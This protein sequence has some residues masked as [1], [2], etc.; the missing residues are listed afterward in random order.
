MTTSCGKIIE[1]D[2]SFALAKISSIIDSQLSSLIDFPI[3]KP[4]YFKIELAI[5]PTII[6][7]LKLGIK[8]LIKPI[9][10]E[11]FDPPII[12]VTGFFISLVI[13]FKAFISVSN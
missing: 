11:I 9:F 5:P 10:D 6:I 7:L 13:F 2:L 3:I 1:H 4:L 12:Q 8:F